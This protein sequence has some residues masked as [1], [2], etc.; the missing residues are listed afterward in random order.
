MFCE[1][2]FDSTLGYPGEGPAKSIWD[3]F[4]KQEASSEQ[5][6]ATEPTAAPEM[7]AVDGTSTTPTAQPLPVAELQQHELLI[8]YAEE[9]LANQKVSGSGVRQRKLDKRGR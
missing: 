3:F 5:Q 2:A 9:V 7:G 8:A 6:E 1:L 4:K